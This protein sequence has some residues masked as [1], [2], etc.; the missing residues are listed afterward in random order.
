MNPDPSQGIDHT[1]TQVRPPDDGN[2]AAGRKPTGLGEALMRRQRDGWLRGQRVLVEAY[3]GQYPQLL[4]EEESL[5]DL[6]Y[7]EYVLRQEIGDHPQAEEYFERFPRHREPL[8]RQ[9]DLDRALMAETTS[10]GAAGTAT[11]APVSGLG[12]VGKYPLIALL[13]E[14]GQAVVYRAVH[15][16]LGRDVV[17]KLSRSDRLD[18]VPDDDRLRQEGRILTELEHPNLAR[19]YDLDVDRGRVFL[20][21]EYVG[22]R[23]LDRYA[24]DARPSPAQAAALVAPIAR[25]LAVVH[26]KGVVHL[27]VKPKNILIDETGRPRLIDFGLARWRRWWS[28]E[29]SES[30]DV[31]G[32]LAFMAPEQA[33][34]ETERLGPASD[35]FA[36]GGVLFFLLTGRPLFAGASFQEVFQRAR[37]CTFDRSA[38]ASPAIPRRLARICLRALAAEPAARYARAAD[39]AADLEALARRPANRVWYV[40]AAA[41]ALTAL[42]ALGAWR[43]LGQVGPAPQ[44]PPPGAALPRRAEPQPTLTLSLKVWD[45]NGPLELVNAEHLRTGDQFQAVVEAPAE[46]YV[47]L[48]LFT[49]D[50]RLR[51]LDSQKGGLRYPAGKIQWAPLTGTAGTEF[52]LACGRRSGPVDID[53]VQALWPGS[54]PWPTLPGESVLSLRPDKASVE[55]RSRDVGPPIT[56]ED[57]VTAVLNKLEELRPRLREHFECFEGVAFAHEE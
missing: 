46:V 42:L 4:S 37:S 9:L 3:L 52:L 34:G 14:G 10:E 17:I 50:G 28:D 44:P 57:P 12:R 1:A 36:L 16:E 30:G 49:S 25:A 22:G 18:P 31:S 8:R 51:L 39:L 24:R 29:P 11:A 23:S 7:N 21:M 33:R 40:A 20:V 2:T 13:G 35:V 6:I 26:E 55:K 48:F 41:V 19:V 38:L 43:F 5:L 47:A 27:D 54:E 56:H 45:P 53:E 15:P 32:T